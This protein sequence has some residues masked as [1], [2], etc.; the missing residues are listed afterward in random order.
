MTI[1]NPRTPVQFRAWL[2]CGH[3]IAK[4]WSQAPAFMP[5]GGGCSC[6]GH[7]ELH[8]DT[9][10]VESD[11]LD[12]LACRYGN[13]AEPELA[14]FVARRIASRGVTFAV[15]LASLDASPLSG[16]AAARLKSDLHATIASLAGARLGGH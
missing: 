5:H 15:W 1:D 3:D 16:P 9:S 2:P 12:Y 6:A 14:D 13:D 10:A 11:I 8:L 7:I 4:S